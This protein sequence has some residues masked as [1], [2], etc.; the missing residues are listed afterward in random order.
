MVPGT[1]NLLARL[2]M[3]LALSVPFLLAV[4]A[5]GKAPQPAPL[6]A[7]APLPALAFDQYL[8]D[9]GKVS[10]SEEVTA[11]FRFTNVGEEPVTIN[12]L[13]PSCGCL[14]PRV[15]KKVYQPGEMD[16]FI[17]R[18][19][20]ANQA[21]GEKEYQV[22]V[23]YADPQPRESLLVFRVNLP[24]NQVMVRPTGMI[25]YQLSDKSSSQ[26]IVV[27]DRREQPLR[28]E[29]VRLIPDMQGVE[30]AVQ[31][32]DSDEHGHARHHVKVTVSG[33]VADGR[34]VGTV[35]LF[36]SD[37]KYPTLRVPIIVQ[38][39]SPRMAGRVPDAKD[40]RRIQLQ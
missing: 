36:T 9:L 25:F 30:V 29:G 18:V 4:A 40:R 32:S 39:T 3:G 34:H 13:V 7:A 2:P 12:Q 8:V 15:R 10:P 14:Q 17:L 28:L 19:Q 31:P 22:T 16:D 26:D 35:M 5:H 27:T 6:S 11:R 1:R 33:D 24:D 23:K 20:T 37:P 21:V 38:G